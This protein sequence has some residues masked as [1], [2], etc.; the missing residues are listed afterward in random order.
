MLT[1]P[2]K[3]I[4]PDASKATFT[5]S[6][7]SCFLANRNKASTVSGDTVKNESHVETS[8]HPLSSS[9]PGGLPSALLPFPAGSADN[10]PLTGMLRD[11]FESNLGFSTS[12][13]SL[14]VVFLKL[15]TSRHSR[16]K[17]GLSYLIIIKV[18]NIF[19]IFSIRYSHSHSHQYHF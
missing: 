1:S 19:V 7:S 11:N 6:P 10:L 3:N 16:N 15:I 5:A 2:F 18:C 12:H 8:Y 14:L 9:Q 13:R 17:K 4:F